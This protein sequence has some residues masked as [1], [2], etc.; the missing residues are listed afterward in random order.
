M[1]IDEMDALIGFGKP[2]SKTAD[3]IV[4]TYLPN[5]PV[6]YRLSIENAV[7]TAIVEATRSPVESVPVPVLKELVQEWYDESQGWNDDEIA[8]RKC[9]DRLSA[10]VKEHKK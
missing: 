10:I 3:W 1:T 9:A 5:A 4:N 8:T 6:S 7:A 2:A